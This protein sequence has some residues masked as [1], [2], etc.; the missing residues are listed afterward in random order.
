MAPR[1]GE[2]A[3]VRG[4]GRAR[5]QAGLKAANMLGRMAITRGQQKSSEP[6]ISCTDFQTGEG[7]SAMVSGA[8]E[9]LLEEAF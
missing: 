2:K 8:P 9:P 4:H 5:L 7:G 6:Y 3:T 1:P